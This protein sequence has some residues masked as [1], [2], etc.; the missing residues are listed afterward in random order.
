MV[1][2]NKNRSENFLAFVSTRARNGSRHKWDE[3][4]DNALQT[5]DSK[6]KPWMS[7]VE[8]ATSRSWKHSQYWVL[9]V[10]GEETCLFFSKRQDRETNPEL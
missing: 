4:D 10:D 8:H 1:K 9:R 2:L 3:W 5:E 7:E 6:F